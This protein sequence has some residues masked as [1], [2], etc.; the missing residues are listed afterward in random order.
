MMMASLEV[1][2][3]VKACLR[4]S[5]RLTRAALGETLHPGLPYRIMAAPDVITPLE[6]IIFIAEFSWSVIRL[7]RIYNF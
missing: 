7:K 2:T 3:F 4:C 5:P 6:G 1:I